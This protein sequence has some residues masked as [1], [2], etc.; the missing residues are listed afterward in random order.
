MSLPS[1][2]DTSVAPPIGVS[3]NPPS[4]LHDAQQPLSTADNSQK[5][6]GIPTPAYNYATAAITPIKQWTQTQPEHTHTSSLASSNASAWRSTPVQP[7][8]AKKKQ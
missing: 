7:E 3:T 8:E 5:E 6:P 4:Q 2:G 1:V